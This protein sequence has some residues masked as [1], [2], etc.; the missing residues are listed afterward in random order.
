MDLV[1]K[2]DWL[3]KESG[4]TKQEFL[5]EAGIRQKDFNK[6]INGV[7]KPT[8]RQIKK[9]SRRCGLS[10]SFFFN[11]PATSAETPDANKRTAVAYVDFEHWCIALYQKFRMRPNIKEWVEDI[12]NRAELKEIIFFGDFSK[13]LLQKEISE[14]RTYTNRIIDTQNP[15][16]TKKDFT[17][18]IMIDQVYQ[19]I[20][21][22][23]E[24]D[25][26]FFVTGDGHF[27]SVISFLVN[28]CKKEVGIY[29]IKECI[30]NALK[31]SASWYIEIPAEADMFVEYY[32]LI[33]DNLYY[34][35]THKSHVR[36]TFMKT[37]EVVSE[38]SDVSSE[39]IAAAL[40]KLIEDDYIYVLEERLNGSFLG[41]CNVLNVDWDKVENDHVWINTYG[42]KEEM[43]LK[44]Q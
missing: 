27:N 21:T 28:Y 2:I 42:T 32:R 44:S 16:R 14:I 43:C 9:I 33:F 37:V 17:D 15:D 20:I 5:C 29:G 39:L 36:P 8:L 3:C 30:S 6:W 41:T 31:K 13:P 4:K 40:R 22:S 25:T 38:R 10:P 12:Y 24:I 11:V 34:L 7:S 26:Y 1:E 35:K 19:R 18:F 23:P